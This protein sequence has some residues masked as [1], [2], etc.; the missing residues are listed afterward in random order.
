MVL[1]T[2][3][4]PDSLTQEEIENLKKFKILIR[5]RY[6]DTDMSGYPH[7][8]KYFIWLEEARHALLRELGISYRVLEKDGIFFPIFES[9][10]KYLDSIEMD[11]LIEVHL[12]I[13]KANKRLIKF[14]YTL[15]DREKNNKK[16]AEA[17]TVHIVV[18]NERK[19]IPLPEKY[20]EL[21][22][23]FKQLQKKS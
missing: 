13:L 7:H 23:V 4:K 12:E 1:D 3:R 14:V 21:L 20:L 10:C 15:I 5:V 2:F 16:V 8:S 6:S 19:N 9:K 18:N 17:E 22:S 11:D